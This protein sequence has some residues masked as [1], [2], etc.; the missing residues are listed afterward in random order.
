MRPDAFARRRM[1]ALAIS[2]AALILCTA[3]SWG[4]VVILNAA[5]TA[6]QIAEHVE[7]KLRDAGIRV[8][9]DEKKAIL[10]VE[11]RKQRISELYSDLNRYQASYQKG[12]N[13][14]RLAEIAEDKRRLRDLAKQLPSADATVGGYYL[15]L[16]RYREQLGPSVK[17]AIGTVETKLQTY[18]KETKPTNPGPGP[19]P[20]PGG[21][22]KPGRDFEIYVISVSGTDLE[23]YLN[24]AK[25]EHARQSFPLGGKDSFTLRALVMGSRRKQGRDFKGGPSS[26][27][28]IQGDYRLRYSVKTDNFK[29][30]TDW[31]VE[32][33]T[34][35]WNVTRQPNLQA[36]WDILPSGKEVTVQDDVVAFKL[37]GAFSFGASVTGEVKWVGDS[38]RPAGKQTLRD[39]DKGSGSIQLAVGPPGP[40]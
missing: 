5:Q 22:G 24:E 1:T 31:I 10:D 16:R 29:G 4:Q 20:P 2:A 26:T 12:N 30:T 37:E 11:L 34:Y 25:V 35:K 19:K 14:A 32:D 18:S 21:G 28:E 8:N 15:D 36:S 6:A 13:A 7:Q 27:L 3:V 33:E 38:E 17:S 9:P 23:F 40:K 39:T